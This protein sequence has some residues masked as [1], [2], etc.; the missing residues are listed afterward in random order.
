MAASSEDDI[1]RRPIRRVR[2]K[3][4][5]PYLAE[6]RISFNLGAGKDAPGAAPPPCSSLP[7]CCAPAPPGPP[8]RPPA[9]ALPAAPP[10]PG[11]PHSRSLCLP[12][13]EGVCA[14]C[15]VGEGGACGPASA[16]V[17]R[18]LPRHG[19]EEVLSVTTVIPGRTR[20]PGC[21]SGVWRGS[22]GEV[23]WRGYYGVELVGD[24]QT[25]LALT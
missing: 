21:A 19:V 13:A 9:L 18:G 20:S 22:P 2:S 10:Q 17:P 11:A 8:P 3:S 23:G 5:T 15:G 12:C 4:D 25:L 6:A 16:R 7:G 1:D 14:S 24:I